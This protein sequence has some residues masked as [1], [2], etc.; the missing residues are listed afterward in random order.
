[1]A[2]TAGFAV[3]T[4]VAWA[5]PRDSASMPSA[6]EP[7]NRS[8]TQSPATGPMMSNTASRTF[9]D[10]GRVAAPRGARNTLP[11]RLPPTIRTAENY[12]G[13]ARRRASQIENFTWHS[14]RDPF[15]SPLQFR[16]MSKVGN[17]A[18]WLLDGALA[19]G[20]GP[21]CALREGDRA[22]T[23][24][25]LA[26]TVARLSA[27]L[28]GLRLGRG[29]R[30]LVLMRD[31]LEAAAAIL[32]VIHAGAVAVP[33]SELATPD[34]LREYVLHAGAVLAIADASHER[35]LDAI[36]SETP[37]LRE[38]ICVDAKLASSQSFQAVVD[39]AV[40]QPPVAM[41]PTD[42]CLLLYSSGSGPGELRAV[43]HSQRTVSA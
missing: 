43:P 34:D 2:C 13:I 28:R 42:T 27:A 9:S 40:A 10:V 20:A 5:A 16:G 35:V 29:E 31:T 32:G 15:G 18:A 39:A 19:S 17:L 38:G 30:V 22:W 4:K 11:P 6:P 7:A 8:R 14:P 12:P 21:R 33:V 36:R 41:A 26:G 25:E 37:E 3:S 1:M 24:D 23:F